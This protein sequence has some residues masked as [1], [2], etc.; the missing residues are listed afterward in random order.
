MSPLRA[1]EIFACLDRHGVRYVLIG[2][3]AAVLHGSPLQTFDADI[4]PD[5]EAGNLT[6]L[7]AALREMDARLRTP[8]AEKGVAFPH[9]ASFLANQH[10]LDLMTRFGDLDLAFEPAGTS[11]F[12]EL[13][14]G[15]EVIAIQGIAVPV[16]RLE[17]VIRSKEAANRPKDQRA[18]PV[19]RLLLEEIEKRRR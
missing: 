3:L 13:L 15:A 18:L 19:L 14:R 10:L 4:C 11:G 7:A 9:E 12:A 1:D 5:R 17:D 6:K 8:D 2:G 16:A